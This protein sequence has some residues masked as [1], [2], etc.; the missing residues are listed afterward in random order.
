MKE[1]IAMTK[2]P[3]TRAEAEK[4]RYGI[5]IVIQGDSYNPDLCAGEFSV[6]GVRGRFTHQ[7]LLRPGEGPA[8]LYCAQ[9]AKM[10]EAWVAKE[11]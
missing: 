11:A 1:I 4:R 6:S 10:V 8:G 3:M 5:P 9:H 2:S 7:C